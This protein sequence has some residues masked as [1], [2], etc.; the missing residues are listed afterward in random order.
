M[1]LLLDNFEDIVDPETQEFRDTEMDEALIALLNAPHH[2]VKAILTTRVAPR[3]LAL[4]QPG[5]QCR[6]DLDDGLGSPSRK[7]SCAR[8]I[9]TARWG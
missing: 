1:V 4:I 2:A 6:L 5:R 3:D 7:T 9:A 8:W